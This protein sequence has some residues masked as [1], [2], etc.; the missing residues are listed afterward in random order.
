MKNLLGYQSL[1]AL[2]VCFAS[3]FST[4]SLA[5]AE[6][7]IRNASKYE[8][9]EVYVS[10][11]SIQSWGAD[12]LKDDI[13]A[14]E[15][16]LTLSGVTP[17]TWDFKLVFREKGGKESWSCVISGI[18]LDEDGDDSTF[19]G[20]MLDKCWEHTDEEEDTAEE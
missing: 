13:L 9:T 4:M 18:E 3:T 11:Q 19:T 7:V 5:F 20:A 6:V 2:I 15:G 8:I 16:K 10:P 17:G 14:P 1:F 12:S